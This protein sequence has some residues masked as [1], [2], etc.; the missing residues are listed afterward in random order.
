MPC[1]DQVFGDAVGPVLGAAEHQGVVHGRLQVLDQ[2]GQQPALVRLGNVIQLLVDAV[3]RAGHRVHLHKGGVPQDAGGQ[4]LD[5]SGHGGAEHQV[6]PAGGQL[7]D[8]LFHVVDKAHVQHPVGFVQHKDLHARQVH[9][10]LSDQVVQAARD[11]PPGCPPPAGVS[12]PEG[13][14]PPRQRSPSPSGAGIC[15]TVQS[16]PRSGGPAPGWG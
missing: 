3:H 1:P 6:L 12:P 14:G 5:L 10:P 15:R 7:C 2:P 16:W 13:P 4:L 9:I 11:R 8:H